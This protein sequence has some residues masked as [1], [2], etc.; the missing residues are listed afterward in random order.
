MRTLSE[1]QDLHVYLGQKADL[2]V[3]QECAAQRRLSEAEAD[4]ETREWEKR[5]SY[6]DL[7]EI[8][9]E[10]E[11]LRLELYQA[12]QWADQA[13]G[14]RVNLCG[15]LEMR[16]RLFQESRGTLP[17]VAITSLNPD[18]RV[19]KQVN[20]DMLRLMGSQA[21]SRRKVMEKVQLPC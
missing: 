19:V 16:N 7:Y 11:S 1:R 8:N 12:H 20:S 15:E 2:A 3:R 6:M 5:S 18:A 10:L 14:Q 13:Q 9:R 4:M 21:R 17:C